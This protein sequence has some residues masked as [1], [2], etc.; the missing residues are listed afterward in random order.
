MSK[1]L[2]SKRDREANIKAYDR[3][4]KDFRDAAERVALGTG[5][6]SGMG[7][8]ILGT[9]KY[10]S[11]VKSGWPIYKKRAAISIANNALLNGGLGATVG[12]L[13]TKAKGSKVNK[14]RS[15]SED[16][17]KKYQKVADVNR[18]ASGKM[19]KEDFIE[20]YGKE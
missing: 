6:G 20:K 10:R 12:Y 17:D 15:K 7:S 19:S 11:L 1:N 5:I 16:A 2:L 4:T 14:K 18:V 3:D 8:A 13:A 9:L